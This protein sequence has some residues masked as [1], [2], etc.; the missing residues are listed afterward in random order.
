MPVDTTKL[1][2]RVKVLSINICLHKPTNPGV[3]TVAA[4]KEI[5]GL[6]IMIKFT[7]CIM[8]D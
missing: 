1:Q 7:I 3:A 4:T 5:W 8:V 6:T 2:H